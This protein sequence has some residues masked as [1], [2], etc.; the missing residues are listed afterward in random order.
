MR[1]AFHKNAQDKNEVPKDKYLKQNKM[2][3]ELPKCGLSCVHLFKKIWFSQL[4]SEE[5]F[6]KSLT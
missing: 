4:I 5:A 2:K 6:M 3:C 1:A